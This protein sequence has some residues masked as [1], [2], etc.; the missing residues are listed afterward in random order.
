MDIFE[1]CVTL[2]FQFEEFVYGL[3]SVISGLGFITLTVVIA[4][5]HADIF[6]LSAFSVAFCSCMVDCVVFSRC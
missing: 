1:I 5:F 2:L 6:L 4:V 3:A